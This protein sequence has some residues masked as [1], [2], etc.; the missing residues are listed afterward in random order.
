MALIAHEL[1]HAIQQGVATPLAAPPAHA[2][3]ARTQAAPF[4]IQRDAK[5]DLSTE[6]STEQVVAVSRATELAQIKKSLTGWWISDG[7]VEGVV[8]RIL[9]N[10]EGR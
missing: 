3:E 8:L 6:E 4:G 1:A 2:V 7:D 5:P 9:E 10:V